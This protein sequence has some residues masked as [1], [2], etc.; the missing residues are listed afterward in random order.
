MAVSY[1]DII[2]NKYSFNAGQYFNFEIENINITSE[3]FENSVRI[4]KEQ[5]YKYNK[6]RNLLDE[7]IKEF[8]EKVF[9]E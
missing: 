9:Y 5:I 1:N 6:D 7:Q 4:F 8:M 2:N 3:E